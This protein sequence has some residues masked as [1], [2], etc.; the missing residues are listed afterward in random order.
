MNY[1]NIF[2]T[3]KYLKFIKHAEKKKI[4]CFKVKSSHK[5]AFMP[6]VVS[7]SK[8]CSLRYGGIMTNCSARGFK[9]SV[10]KHFYEHCKKHSIRYFEIR[11]DPFMD[12]ITIGRKTKKEPFV[13]IDLGKSLSRL[14]SSI[15]RPHLEAIK[16]S[17]SEDLKILEARNKDY[18]VLFFKLYKNILETKEVL[19]HPLSYFDKM[20]HFLGSN[21]SF[22]CV[23]CK[24]NIIAS[25]ILLDSFPNVFLMY[26]G[27]NELGY[28]KFA[29]YFMVYNLMRIYKKRGF[30]RLILGTGHTE[31]DAIYKFKQGFTDTINYIETF[32]GN[33]DRFRKN[34]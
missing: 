18:L 10:E 21:M 34:F 6:Y 2:Y 15:S 22:V 27:M 24:K 25:S 29:K 1:K 32:S 16:R 26:G 33:I 5:T 28:R 9:L 19:P 4:H 8:L 12:H 13:Y 11:H 14:R 31:H 23:S 30:R 17:E 20:F 3:D 7:D